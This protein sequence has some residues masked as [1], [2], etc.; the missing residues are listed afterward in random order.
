MI[1]NNLALYTQ[2]DSEENQKQLWTRDL[3]SALNKQIELELTNFATYQELSNYLSH[4]DQGMLGL[5][6]HF[7]KE[8]DEELKHARNFMNY[9]TKRGGSVTSVNSMPIDISELETATNKM[10][11]AYQIALVQEKFTYVALLELHEIACNDPAL[12]DLI[13]ESLAEQL[14]GQQELNNVIKMLELG[15]SVMCAIHEEKLRE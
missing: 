13:E 9:Q 8:A 6:N 12:Q 2:G 15:G 11:K 3:E 10:L 7:Q 5:S 14:N 4:A 1:D